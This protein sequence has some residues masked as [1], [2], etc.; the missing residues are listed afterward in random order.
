MYEEYLIIMTA[1]VTA[2]IRIRDIVY[3]ERN[4]RKIRIVT[5]LEQYEYYEKM[6]NL[7][8]LLD[9]RFFPCLKGLYIN[10]NKVVS[11]HDRIIT[12][13]GGQTLLIGRE[14]FLKTAQYYKFYLKNPVE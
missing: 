14:N 7:E 8:P 13:E 1:S 10:L 2:R 12:F 11:M 4:K 5:D 3:I 6:K 9:R